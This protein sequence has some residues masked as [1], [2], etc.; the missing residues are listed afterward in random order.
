MESF[1][2]RKP[3]AGAVG[4]RFFDSFLLAAQRKG[5]AAGLPPA[6]LML[7]LIAGHR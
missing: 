3:Q 4:R 2:R 7:V 6:N 1:N 5:S